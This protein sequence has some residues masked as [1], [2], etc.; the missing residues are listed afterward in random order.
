MATDEG[1]AAHSP[2]WSLVQKLAAV[3]V[4]IGAIATLVLLYLEAKTQDPAVAMQVFSTERLTPSL[5]AP[6]L[7]ARFLHQGEQVEDLWVVRAR[8]ANIGN[9]TLVNQG[10]RKNII[11]S[12]INF[13][14]PDQVTLLE[15]IPDTTV[16]PLKVEKSGSQ[17]L[18]VVFRQWRPGE[19]R[20][21]SFY[22]SSDTT[23]QELPLPTSPSRDIINGRV[24]VERLTL[25]EQQEAH[26]EVD[27]LPDPLASVGRVVGGVTASFLIFIIG[28]FFVVNNVWEQIQ[29]FWWERQYG[30]E[31]RDFLS[32]FP[33]DRFEEFHKG[34]STSPSKDDVAEDPWMAD[35]KLWLEFDGEEYPVIPDFGS[36]SEAISAFLIGAALVVGLVVLLADLGPV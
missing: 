6:N 13:E 34:S 33:D 15:A 29:I 12:G 1:S 26:S 8:L 30:R 23:L 22:V 11:G 36:T 9:V 20:S 2:I 4:V 14:F 16:G 27:R 5:E 24:S 32:S 19:T 28:A 18:R 31:F 10:P 7:D 17:R 21:Y 3:A 25:Q 35:K